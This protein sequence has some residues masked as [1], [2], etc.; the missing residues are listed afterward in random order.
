MSTLGGVCAVLFE[1]DLDATFYLKLEQ[2][3]S[4]VERLDLSC[5]HLSC[6]TSALRAVME[7]LCC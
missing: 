4:L 1:W 2:M 7:Q 3:Q 6:I 5:R